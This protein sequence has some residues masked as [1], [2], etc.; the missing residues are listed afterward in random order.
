MSAF[1]EPLLLYMVLFFPGFAANSIH[2]NEAAAAIIPFSSTR[3]LNRIIVY[4]LPTLAF[5]WYMIL[6]KNSLVLFPGELR[7]KLKDL[8][9]FIW[10]FSGLILIGMGISFIITHTF[11]GSASSKIQAPDNIIGW[12]VLAFSCLG[13]GYLEESFFRF[14]LLLKLEEVIP[15]RIPKIIFTTLLFALSHAYEGP[16]GVLNAAFAGLLLS[17][18][19]ERYRSL[20][21]IAIAHAFYN[22]FVYVMGNFI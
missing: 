19:F 13:T 11:P 22:A 8:Y 17:L 7:F 6:K 14:Y 10:G 20:H 15:Y 12:I 16:W 18:L 3:E 2:L 21:G 9:C 1:F 5:L 4:I